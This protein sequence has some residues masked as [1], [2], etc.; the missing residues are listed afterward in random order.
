MASDVLASDILAIN[1]ENT[2]C[3]P[4][5]TEGKPKTAFTPTSSYIGVNF[6]TYVNFNTGAQFIVLVPRL[7]LHLLLFLNL[8]RFTRNTPYPYYLFNTLNK[9]LY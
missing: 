9:I 4:F 3:N 5:K 8:G 1:K 6:N 7:F 2:A